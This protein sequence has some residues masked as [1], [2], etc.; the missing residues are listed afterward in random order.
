[1]V[2]FNTNISWWY[3]FYD[4]RS[5]KYFRTS[6]RIEWGFIGYYKTYPEIFHSASGKSQPILSWTHYRIL[7]QVKDEKAREWY[8]KEALQQAWS[9]RTL[10]RNVSSQY[11]YRMLQTQKKDLVENEMNELTKEYQNDKLEFIKIRLLQNF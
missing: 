9:V 6:W 3:D 1:M 2:W 7:L 11:Y 10:Q 4:I 5:K 8:E